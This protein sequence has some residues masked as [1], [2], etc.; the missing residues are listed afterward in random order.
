M[1]ALLTTLHQNPK[2]STRFNSQD[3]LGIRTAIL[4]KATDD[5][6]LTLSGDYSRQ[7]PDCCAQIFVRVGATQRPLDRQFDRL[8][9]AQGYEPPSR[10]PFDPNVFVTTSFL[11]PMW[12]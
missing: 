12:P 5:L 8:A 6:D 7:N 10:N 3:N 2:I 9:A 4:W 1:I 11:R